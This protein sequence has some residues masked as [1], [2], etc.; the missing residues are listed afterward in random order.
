[1]AFAPESGFRRA[2]RGAFKFARGHVVLSA[3]FLA[4]I[5]TMAFVPPD[6]AYAGYIDARTIACLFGILAVAGALKRAGAFEKAARLV[7]RRFRTSRSAVFSLVAATAVLSMFATNDMALI[8]M[9]PLAA[10]TLIRAGWVRL[11][12]FTFVMLGLTANL[13]GMIMPFGNP[14][15]LYLYS[16]YAIGLADFLSAMALP[17]VASMVL[18]ALC[19][20]VKVRKS[21]PA[22]DSGAAASDE[23][24]LDRRRLALYI[25]LFA[26]CVG[27]VLR[28]VPAPV[29]V[30]AVVVGLLAAD[31]GALAAVDYPLL[32]TFVCFFVFSGNLSRI[33]EVD[34]FLG[35]VVRAQ[36][37]L[38]SAGLSQVISNVPAAVLLSHFTDAWQ[39]LLVGVN[40]GGAGTLVGSLASL[41]TLQQ[42]GLVRRVRAVR[43]VEAASM[44]R[45]VGLFF[46]YNLS[47]L[48]VLVAVCSFA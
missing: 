5:V 43:L 16:S 21:E 38:V 6:A 7:V 40:I 24:P 47:F 23:A 4:A 36:P 10:A 14:Q 2:L 12:P 41:I 1:M 26:L 48:I 20:A 27:M 8:M 25:A 13:G 15:N 45:F 17:F 9:L 28:V 35:D 11:L 44:K 22:A 31:R 18:V 19:C 32:L 33:P 29:A 34:A 37:L 46:G 3:S 30:A 42:Y 39:P